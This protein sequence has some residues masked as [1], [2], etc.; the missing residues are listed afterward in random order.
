MFIVAKLENKK[1]EVYQLTIIKELKLS[2]STK[3][4]KVYIDGNSVK[5]QKESKKY[6]MPNETGATGATGA[7]GEIVL[8]YKG[9]GYSSSWNYSNSTSYSIYNEYCKT[10]EDIFELFKIKKEK[11][12]IIEIE[13]T[14][15]YI[16]EI[17]D[18]LK[19]LGI[20]EKLIEKKI[21]GLKKDLMNS[22]EIKNKKI[23]ELENE[24]NKLKEMSI[25]D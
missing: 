14:E 5:V 2:K 15:K 22:K 18:F 10:S 11:N 1:Y 25:C 21:D 8:K 17:S 23:V 12:K 24:K 3:L 6:N 20:Q 9:A 7:N 16:E 4:Q 19:K 13:E